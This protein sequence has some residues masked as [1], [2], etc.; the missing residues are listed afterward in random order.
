MRKI[1]SFSLLLIFTNTVFSQA[2]SST[3][4]KIE[5]AFTDEFTSDNC[6]IYAISD[7]GVNSLSNCTYRINKLQKSILISGR[8]SYIVGADFIT[9]ILTKK[10]SVNDRSDGNTGEKQLLQHYIVSINELSSIKKNNTPLKLDEQKRFI[11]MDANT[12][13]YHANVSEIN[14][15]RYILNS[16]WIVLKQAMH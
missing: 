14:Y 13:S 16:N 7:K 1:V 9:L 10:K 6:E 5:L 11:K 12:T 3:K 8:L 15:S 2:S 4:F